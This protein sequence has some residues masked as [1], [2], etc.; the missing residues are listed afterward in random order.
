MVNAGQIARCRS[1]PWL[2]SA[3]PV[4]GQQAEAS[5][6]QRTLCKVVGVLYTIVSKKPVFISLAMPP[7]QAPQPSANP[8]Y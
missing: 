8:D 7:L 4:T 2:L 3:S 1:T 6:V 5:G